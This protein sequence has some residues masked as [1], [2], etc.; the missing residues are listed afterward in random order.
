MVKL[1]CSIVGVAGSAFSVEVDEG[2][3]VDDLKEAIKAKK[4]NDFKEV[5]A[6]KLQLFLA[7]KDE[8]R[9]PWLTEEEVKKDVIDTTGLKLLGAARARLRRVGL[10]DVDVGGVDE[11]EEVE[12]RGP[13]NVLVVVPEQDGTISKEMFAATTPLTVEQVEMSM[14][15]V[16]RERDEKASA[17]SFSDLNTAMEEQIV[18]KMRLTENIPDVKEP[19]DTSIAGYSWIPKIVESE[20][21]QRAGYMAYLQQHLKT[22][23]DRGDFLLD[24]IAGDK[25][26]LNIVDP[27]L[28]FAMKGTAD[29]LLINRTSKNPLIKL[30]GVSLVI[31]LK[32]KVEPGHVPQ[33]IGQLVSCSMKAPLNCY[34]LS[35]LTDL[36]DHWH[37]SW[38]SDKHV[39]TQLTLRYPKNAFRF[40]E[41]AVL[42]R[43]ESAPPPPS[44]MPGSFKTIKVD[45]FLPQPGDARAEE[46]M[47]RYELMADVVE[48]EFLMARRMDYAR[49]LVQSMPMYSYMYT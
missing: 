45:D 10:S 5:D 41:A 23:M 35:L 18:K 46:M 28:P 14:N 25:S 39:L 32:K 16:L 31:E 20:E 19:V 34:P 29:V 7:K 44:F 4:A 3:T 2:K 21:S 15:K 36:N 24:D 1:F 12:G 48:P 43:T 49:Q 13:V 38:F 9:G 27:R 42:R 11:D 30:A 8:G 22:L 40:I 37:F 6:D 33:A 26:V 47:E 17:Y